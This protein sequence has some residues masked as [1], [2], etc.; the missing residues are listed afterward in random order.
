[1]VIAAAHGVAPAWS[2]RRVPGQRQ[3][4][5]AAWHRRP[6][7]SPADRGTPSSPASTF[8]TPRRDWYR[9]RTRG[10]AR[11]RCGEV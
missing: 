8:A 1:V 9:H 7:E 3:V 11:P 4:S 6:P 5:E 10:R 2:R